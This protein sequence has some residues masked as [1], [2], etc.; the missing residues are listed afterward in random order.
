MQG[1]LFVE[2]DFADRFFWARTRS[3]LGAP[4]ISK[5]IGCS[6]GLISNIENHGA[7]STQL[8]DK[9]ARLFKVD[10]T[11]LRDGSGPAPRGFDEKEAREMRLRGPAS[12]KAAGAEV[13]SLDDH[14]EPR[15]AGEELAS[16]GEERAAGL[17]RRLFADFQDY[18]GI[19]GQDRAQ[20]LV[21]VL[22]RLTA[23]VQPVA[24]KPKRH[25]D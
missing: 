16:A 14:R 20:A 19:V 7:K 8:N 4:T 2:S 15:W 24:E 23:L 5:K 6:P 10:P 9:F 21:E 1:G 12:S 22:T 17:Q 25:D 18:A 3:G 11:W 13:I